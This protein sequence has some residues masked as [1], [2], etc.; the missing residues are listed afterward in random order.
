M[1]TGADHVH[2]INA[3]IF[4]FSNGYF[5]YYN[6]NA[7]LVLWI[8]TYLNPIEHFWEIHGMEG[9][10]VKPGGIVW[11]NH[12]NME[13]KGSSILWNTWKKY[14]ISNI[15]KRNVSFFISSTFHMDTTEYDISL[16]SEKIE[17]DVR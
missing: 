12:D 17:D 3:T 14:I 13:Q 2:P 6:S 9:A 4:P 15:F 11:C 8:W 16:M 5:Q 10:P 1:S 7:K